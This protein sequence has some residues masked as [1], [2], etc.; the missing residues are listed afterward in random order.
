MGAIATIAG[1]LAAKASAKA[2]TFCDIRWVPTSAGARDELGDSAAMLGAGQL[3]GELG[4][5]VIDDCAGG[6]QSLRLI[7]PAAHAPVP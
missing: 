5:L 2:L 7:S 1:S 4:D 3:A 6:S